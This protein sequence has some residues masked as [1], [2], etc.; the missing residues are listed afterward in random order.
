[1]PLVAAAP[2]ALRRFF[3]PRISNLTMSKRQILVVSLIGLL[4]IGHIAY[5]KPIGLETEGRAK[6]AKAKAQLN[7]DVGAALE[8]IDN[9]DCGS[10]D[11]GNVFSGGGPRRGGPKEV[12]VIV[13]GDIINVDNKCK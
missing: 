8:N 10:V 6:L 3:H 1:M 5:A 7:A 12:N 9:R 4:V 11:I 13:T 2:K